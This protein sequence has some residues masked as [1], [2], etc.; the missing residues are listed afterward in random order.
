[1]RTFS[2]RWQSTLT[3][4]LLIFISNALC[5]TVDNYCFYAGGAGRSIELAVPNDA[6]VIE[7]DSFDPSQWTLEF[8]IKDLSSSLNPTAFSLTLSGGT[9]YVHYRES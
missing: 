3:C 8:W 2:C 1:M 4:I 9:R 5:Q 7:I 6:A